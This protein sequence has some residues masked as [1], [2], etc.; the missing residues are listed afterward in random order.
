MYNDINIS[1]VNMPDSVKAC[2]IPNCTDDSY[3]IIINAKLSS[4]ARQRALQHELQHIKRDDCY[5][6]T[7]IAETLENNIK[8]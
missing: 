3:I 2:T 4:S 8:N 7:E 1:Y 5:N 6:D